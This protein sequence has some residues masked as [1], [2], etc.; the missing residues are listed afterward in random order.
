MGAVHMLAMDFAYRLA[1]ATDNILL[2]DSA[3]R[4]LN[5]LTRTFSVQVETLKRHRSNEQKVVV[6]H[7][8]VNEGGKAIVGA[9]TATKRG[10][11]SSEKRDVTP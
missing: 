2:R 4:T 3:E 6:E 8:T 7:V 5:K 11:G 9:V 10:A 1:N